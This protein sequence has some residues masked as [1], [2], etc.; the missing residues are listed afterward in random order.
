MP[1]PIAWPETLTGNPSRLH[2]PEHCRKLGFWGRVHY[3]EEGN[4]KGMSLLITG[5]WAWGPSQGFIEDFRVIGG[6][7][8]FGGWNPAARAK[9]RVHRQVGALSFGLWG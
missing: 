6:L 5:L 3:R 2:G 8:F 1:K 9:A 7:L 4:Y